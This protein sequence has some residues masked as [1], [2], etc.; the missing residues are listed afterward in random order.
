MGESSSFLQIRKSW[1]SGNGT[2]YFAIPSEI[3]KKLKLSPDSYLL[4][5]LIDDSIIVIKK[6][7]PQFTKTEL[8]KI[9]LHKNV[10]EENPIVIEEKL[11]EEKKEFD[12]PLKNLDL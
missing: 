12:N 6:H 8:N 4:V 11:D 7:D 2:L 9:D 1:I 5:D 3:V 10:T